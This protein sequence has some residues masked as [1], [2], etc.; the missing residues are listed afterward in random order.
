[1]HLPALI[2][3]LTAVTS[4]TAC[5]PDQP[6]DGLRFQH[7]NVPDEFIVHF[8]HLYHEQSRLKFLTAAMGKVAPMTWSVVSRSNPASQ[9]PSDFDVV[10]VS[11]AHPDSSEWIDIVKTH[12]SIKDVTPQQMITRSLHYLNVSDDHA[13]HVP[14][15]EAEWIDDTESES[16]QRWFQRSFPA[17]QQLSW[18]NGFSMESASYSGTDTRRKLLRAI[19]RQITSLLRADI[20]WQLGVTGEGIRVAIF[21]TGLPKSHPHFKKVRERTN[22]TNEKTLD[23][24]LGHGTFVAGVIASS[25]KECMG[26]A[27]NAEL[28]IFRVFTNSQVSYTSWFLDA[29][30]YAILKKVNILNLS[31]GGPDFMD[32]PFVDKVWELTANNIV[33]ISAIGN[34]GPLYG[35]LNNPADQMDVIGVGGINFDEKIAKF[36]SRGMTTWELPAGYGRV[37]PDIVTYGAAV[38]GSSTKGGCRS[39]SGT[40]V[41]SPVVAGATKKW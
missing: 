35:T 11:G 22:W 21:D 15:D 38:R 16:D 27:P 1:M 4:A 29:F 32:H 34:D 8:K 36:S 10:Q 9:F 33:M 12:P 3:I 19:P 37:K 25:H 23:D 41:A 14:S 24:S 13:D 28:Y 39:L 5:L 40:S 17:R 20:L 2:L 26:F 31:I 30:N 6:A 18:L 7:Q